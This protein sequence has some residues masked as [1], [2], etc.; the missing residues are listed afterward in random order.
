MSSETEFEL[1]GLED[2][3]VGKYSRLTKLFLVITILLI[4]LIAVAFLGIAGFGY[5]YNWMLVSLEGW[6][7]IVSVLIA[8][9]I[10]LELLFY[11][12]FSALKNKIKELEKPKPEFVDNKKIYAYTIPK[13]V[14]G[15]VFSKTYIE[16]DEHSALRLRTLII[17]PEE[18]W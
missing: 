17:P 7:I 6:I 4:L 14:E 13:G 16:I 5:G 3:L 11:S 15:G 12:R 10:I 2:K 18:I 9:F 1:R 8:I